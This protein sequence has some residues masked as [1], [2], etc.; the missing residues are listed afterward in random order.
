MI[1]LQY[2]PLHYSRKQMPVEGIYISFV[3]IIFIVGHEQYRSIT[4][5]HMQI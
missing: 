4:L 5:N 2:A 3:V 1:C